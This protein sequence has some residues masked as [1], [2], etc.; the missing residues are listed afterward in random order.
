MRKRLHALT[1]LV[2]FLDVGGV[3]CV[4]YSIRSA[5]L[6]LARNISGTVFMVL[7][8]LLI[9]QGHLLRSKRHYGNTE[10]KHQE[11]I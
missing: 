10:G 9:K 11:N 2:I 3:V 8:Y 4:V 5:D 6:L 7:V 1:T